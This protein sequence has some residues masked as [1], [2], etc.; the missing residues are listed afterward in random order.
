M[1]VYI[2]DRVKELLEN[3]LNITVKVDKF[4]TS[5]FYDSILISPITQKDK[6]EIYALIKASDEMTLFELNN[7]ANFVLDKSKYRTL[8]I[9]NY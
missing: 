3:L 1:N 2:K 9:L 5:D 7:N 8:L 6:T 4:Y